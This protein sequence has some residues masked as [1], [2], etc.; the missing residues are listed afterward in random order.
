LTS[1]KDEGLTFTYVDPWA[2]QWLEAPPRTSTSHLATDPGSWP[3]AAQPG[4]NAQNQAWWK[5]LAVSATLK[6]ETCP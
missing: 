5:Q 4:L 6:S 1:G 2:P 3:P